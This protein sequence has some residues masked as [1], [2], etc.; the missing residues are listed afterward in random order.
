MTVTIKQEIMFNKLITK[1]IKYKIQYIKY[2]KNTCFMYKH[3]IDVN[4]C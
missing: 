3:I 4:L 2:M 1:L